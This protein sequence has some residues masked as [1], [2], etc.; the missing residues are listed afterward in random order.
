MII[1]GQKNIVSKIGFIKNDM[2]T[3]QQQQRQMEIRI[4]NVEALGGSVQTITE[5]VTCKSRVE[6]S[7]NALPYAT[8]DAIFGDV[9]TDSVNVMPYDIDGGF[10][11]NFYGSESITMYGLT[12]TQDHLGRITVSGTSS[13][14]F[15]F[16]LFDSWF[17]FRP[18]NGTYTGSGCPSGGDMSTYRLRFILKDVN[19]A[20]HP[21]Y[22]KGNG[23]EPFT[24]DNTIRAMN[25][26]F[27]VRSSGIHF[28]NTIILPQIQ[29][30]NIKTAWEPYKYKLTFA[31]LYAIESYDR[32]GNLVDTFE[33][34][35]EVRSLP[36]YGVG[37]GYTASLDLR[38]AWYTD[39]YGYGN[40]VDLTNKQYYNVFSTSEWDGQ[41]IPGCDDYGVT[42]GIIVANTT[43]DIVVPGEGT[44]ISECIAD[45]YIKIGAGGYL[46]LKSNTSVPCSIY[47]TYQK[48]VEN[49]VAKTPF[50][51]ANGNWWIGDTDTGEKAAGEDGYTP[52]KGIDYYTEAE[53]T[54]MVQRV[55]NALPNGDEV[56]Y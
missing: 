40:A 11:K 54:E 34:P 13:Q 36:N 37:C 32:E 38:S 33:V 47:L 6:V 7:E 23:T 20:D 18:E 45:N 22:D 44:D 3:F 12:F 14:A 1:G 29:A 10:Y 51:G 43:Y 9:S 39:L 31:D 46:L 28:S 15:D 25:V 27:Q 21:Y 55:L 41:S 2:R 26:V 8:V 56:S 49:E 5:K 42:D 48:C 19:G 17:G 24:V 4:A 52:R 35:D 16:V 50:I 53:T 30:G